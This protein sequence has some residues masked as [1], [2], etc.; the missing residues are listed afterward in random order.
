MKPPLIFELVLVIQREEYT[1]TTNILIIY[2]TECNYL[3]T[4]L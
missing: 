4:I 1:N 2:V 3:F